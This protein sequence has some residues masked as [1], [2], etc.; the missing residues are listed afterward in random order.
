MEEVAGVRTTQG[1]DT[2][3]NFNGVGHS[4]DGEPGMPLLWCLG[5]LFVRGK[6]APVNGTADSAM[7]TFQD[8]WK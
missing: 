2:S 6:A 1:Q 5:Y 7:T 4:F 8:R 3:T